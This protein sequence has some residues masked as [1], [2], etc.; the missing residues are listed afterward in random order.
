MS[1]VTVVWSMIVSACLT[2]AGLHVLVWLRQ[3]KAWGNLLFS[4]SAK[5]RR[6][7]CLLEFAPRQRAVGE[8]RPRSARSCELPE[9]IDELKRI[10]HLHLKSAGR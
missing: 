1:W 4:L 2:L 6:R 8:N 5:L 7:R 9:T 3:R 10:L